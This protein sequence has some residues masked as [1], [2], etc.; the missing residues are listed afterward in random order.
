MHHPLTPIRA[1]C[2][3]AFKILF[4]IQI[5]AFQETDPKLIMIDE[6]SVTAQIRTPNKRYH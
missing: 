3:K 2:Q 5:K 6:N 4:L 1:F